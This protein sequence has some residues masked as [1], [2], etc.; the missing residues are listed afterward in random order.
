MYGIYDCRRAPAM[1]AVAGL[2][3][4][5]ACLAQP[6]QAQPCP[7]E[8]WC[9]SNVFPQVTDVELSCDGAKVAIAGMTKPG[10]GAAVSIRDAADG[11]ELRRIA[12]PGLPR[13]IAWRPG[14]SHVAC[15][16]MTVAN[17]TAHAVQVYD[18][19]T[20]AQVVSM[21]GITVAP[22]V[23]AYSPDGTT[24]AVGV[25]TFKVHLFNAETGSETGV[26]TSPKIKSMPTSLA[27][28]ADSADL[29]IGLGQ[30]N[31]ANRVKVVHLANGAIVQSLTVDAPSRQVDAVR[32]S[33]DGTKLAATNGDGL[34]KVWN[35]A[36]WSE[37]RSLRASEI[38]G[39]VRGHALE[40]APDGDL[41]AWGVGPFP[42]ATLFVRVSTGETVAICPEGAL[43]GVDFTPD[44]SRWLRGSDYW[45]HGACLYES[46]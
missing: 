23:G 22:T 46:P 7:N 4:V 8:V 1:P 39:S 19:D 30:G 18:A 42:L 11:N 10:E 20:G 25:Q 36:D 29:A 43:S 44:G 21:T 35:T 15:C 13:W 14:T 34:L 24:L 5:M 16:Y 9:A 2:V 12:V 31:E 38:T 41:L 40:F 26:I 27:F 32:Y 28:S 45:G 17:P 37:V 33:Q 6:A 3:L